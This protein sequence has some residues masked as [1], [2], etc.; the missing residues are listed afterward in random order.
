MDTIIGVMQFLTSTKSSPGFAHI[1]VLI[2]LLSVSSSSANRNSVDHFIPKSVP[3]QQAYEWD[4]YRLCRARLN[5]RKGNH[6]DVLDPFVVQPGWFVLDFRTF[7]LHPSSSLSDDDK[8]LVTAT[9]Q[10]LKLNDDH[11][12]VNERIGAIR[13]YCLG[14]ASFSQLCTKFP[15]ISS[16]MSRQ[17]FDT[18]FLPRMARTF[19]AM[20][21]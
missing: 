14:E 21:R 2:P 1:A 19:K 11:D 16:E 7:L 13:S 3:P 17:D 4:N 15:F 6:L 8:G 9:I 10:R 5:N 12:Y 20:H 18:H